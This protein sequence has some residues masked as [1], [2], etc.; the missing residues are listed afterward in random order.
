[1]YATTL[2]SKFQ[3][4]IPKGIRESMGLQPGQRFAVIAK[5]TTIELVPIGEI[6]KARGRLRGAN[7]QDYRDRKDRV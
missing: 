7:T 6:A 4:S 2:S 5:G 1:M 3:M